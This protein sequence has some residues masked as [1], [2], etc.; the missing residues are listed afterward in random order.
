MERE[1]VLIM[2]RNELEKALSVRLSEEGTEAFVCGSTYAEVFNALVTLEPVLIVAEQQPW[3][4]RLE[5]DI[6]R[7]GICTEIVSITEEADNSIGSAAQTVIKQLEVKLMDHR[8]RLTE[9]DEYC[10]ELVK[11]LLSELCITPNYS[12]YNYITDILVSMVQ[13]ETDC[14]DTFCK[15]IYPNVGSKYS[16]TPAAVERSIRTAIGRSWGKADDAV[17]C[18]YLGT[19]FTGREAAPSNKEFLFAAANSLMAE[20]VQYKR[21]LRD[22]LFSEKG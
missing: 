17:T 21:S 9:L 1:S 12:G 2:V 18:K 14:R 3:L 19:A 22:K 6:E 5:S 16:I 13:C 7:L 20:V 4:T 15:S 11:T 8:L 10:R